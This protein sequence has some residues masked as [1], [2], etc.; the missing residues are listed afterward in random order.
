MKRFRNPQVLIAMIGMLATLLSV[1]IVSIE[2]V[3]IRPTISSLLVGV[4]GTI[5]GAV[6]AFVFASSF[7]TNPSA[8][9]FV[10]YSNKDFEFAKKLSKDLT[11]N[12]FQVL[13]IDNVVLVGDNIREK[14]I[15]SVQSADFFVIIISKDALESQWI[16]HELELATKSNKKVFPVLKEKIDLPLPIA[17]IQYADFSANYE[18]A[19]SSLI[20][21]LRANSRDLK[22]T[23]A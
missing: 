1:V 16:S 23:S 9:V 12:G 22:S 18:T 14:I 7:E 21:S 6:I 15:D 10:S 19:I 4:V 8:K 20:K 3:N 13:K 11:R 5:L 17:E 2:F